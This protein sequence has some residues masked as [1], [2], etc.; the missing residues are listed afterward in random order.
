MAKTKKAPTNSQSARFLAAAKAA[1]VDESGRKFAQ[2]MGKLA[3]RVR[4]TPKN[5]VG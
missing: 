3:K 2:A 1:G 5:Q 4:K